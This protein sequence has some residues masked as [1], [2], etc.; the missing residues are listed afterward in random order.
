MNCLFPDILD[1][2]TIGT[3]N[4]HIYFWQST[5]SCFYFVII[6]HLFNFVNT[7]LCFYDKL[8]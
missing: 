1:Y 6:T 8:I 7:I 2:N 4:Q 5:K 3:G